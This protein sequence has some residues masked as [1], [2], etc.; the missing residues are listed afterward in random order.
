MIRIPADELTAVIA[1]ILEAA[2]APEPSARL[3]AASLVENNLVGHDSHGA[4]RITTYAQAI[5]SGRLDPHG[6]IRVEAER[7][8]TALIDGGA[9]FGQVVLHRATELAMG[10]AR[11][12]GLGAVAVHHCGHTG[13]MGEYAVRA[14]EEGFI[15]T[16]YGTGSRKGGTVAAY[17]G[18][19]PAFNTNPIAW[20]VPAG[21]F[22]AVFFDYATSVVAWGKIE[23]AIDK[24]VPIPEGWLVDAAGR[25]TTDPHEQRRGGVMLPFGAHK[26]YG[27]AFMIETVAGGL[28]GM[29]CALLESYQSDFGTVVTALDVEAFRPLDGFRRM[30]DEHV[31]AVKAGTRAPGVEEILV[32]GE[33]EWRTRDARLREGIE[34]PEATWERIVDTGMRCGVEVARIG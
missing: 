19:S 1:R 27:L 33:L 7:P 4:L 3:V 26:G 2:G 21:S 32:P 10:K 8:S 25:P 22:P 16:V 15:A 34:L 13:R 29:G 14:A 24:G 20:A 6:E 17:G 9:N 28:S 11:R 31:A 23:A 12:C 5:L 30:V 18:I